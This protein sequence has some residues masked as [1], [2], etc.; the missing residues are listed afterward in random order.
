MNETGLDRTTI[1]RA[2]TVALSD[3]TEV[4][5]RWVNF[6]VINNWKQLSESNLEDR[7]F[8][9]SLLSLLSYDPKETSIRL[10]SWQD[11]KLLELSN[12]YL[13]KF[14]DG[15][16]SDK[17]FS[18]LQARL[19]ID[20]LLSH[21]D[22]RLSNTALESPENMNQW[23]GRAAILPQLGGGIFPSASFRNL[24]ESLITS[25][26]LEF[27]KM[28]QSYLKNLQ[29]TTF[30]FLAPSI[31]LPTIS[32]PFSVS[33]NTMMNWSET[34]R[35]SYE[36][37]L[38]SFG[39]GWLGTLSTEIEALLDEHRADFLLE[40]RLHFLLDS[41]DG[42]I[43][44]F[45][46]EFY[47]DT[48]QSRPTQ[49]TKC[50]HLMTS[51]EEFVAKLLSMIR[52]SPKIRSHGRAVEAGISAHA[53]RN[54]LLSIPALLPQ[55]EALTMKLLNRERYIKWSRS[56]RAWCE[57]DPKT[58]KFRCD[59]KGNPIRVNG[60]GSL[61]GVITR[62]E[63][64]PLPVGLPFLNKGV[65]GYRNA[66]MHGRLVKYDRPRESSRL[67]LLVLLLVWIHSSG[68]G[69]ES[70]IPHDEPF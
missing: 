61:D 34:V 40:Q 32:R 15:A 6:E 11:T 25:P 16:Q 44:G 23:F 57:T 35:T 69:E 52:A 26:M 22:R 19:G 54:Y 8:L 55:V 51:N 37:L 63:N 14:G 38:P 13:K 43:D 67:V 9:I 18:L 29:H 48:S 64:N 47:D 45:V 20:E 50:L 59:K 68:V 53:S 5:F 41:T 3:G 21:K 62:I 36:R 31:P 60:L 70:V 12:Q 28:Q 30:K 10:S 4:Q 17:Y 33:L 7:Q 65:S 1:E 24:Q 49:V 27:S 39:E 66:V 46:R 58:G 2:Q 42:W 56:R